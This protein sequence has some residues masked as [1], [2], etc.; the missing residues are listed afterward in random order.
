MGNNK[1]NHVHKVREH[2]N[3]NADATFQQEGIVHPYFD[4]VI[5]ALTCALIIVIKIYSLSLV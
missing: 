3:R 5:L 1:E 4:K 2:G